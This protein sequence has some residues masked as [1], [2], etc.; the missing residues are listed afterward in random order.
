MR[1]VLTAGLV[2][3]LATLLSSAVTFAQGSPPP[4]PTQTLYQRLVQQQQSATPTVSAV[5][6][7]V[8][9]PGSG[10]VN[11]VPAGNYGILGSWATGNAS[12][13]SFQMVGTWKMAPF[14]PYVVEIDGTIQNTDSLLGASPVILAQAWDGQGHVIGSSRIA[15]AD[16]LAPGESRDFVENMGLSGTDVTSVMSVTLSL[17]SNCNDCR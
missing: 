8:T 14:N 11:V 17:T 15:R 4:T 2:I 10:I 9:G 13:A 16:P 5:S 12:A 1:R 6:T 3:I 7:P